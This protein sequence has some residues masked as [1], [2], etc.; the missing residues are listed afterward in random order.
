MSAGFRGPFDF[1]PRAMAE[2]FGR[3]ALQR[4]QAGHDPR[5]SARLAFSYAIELLERAVL[6]FQPRENRNGPS[7][8][9]D[10]RP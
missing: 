8:S 1:G 6:E 5:E 4:I 3:V 2:R 10:R 7:R 9:G